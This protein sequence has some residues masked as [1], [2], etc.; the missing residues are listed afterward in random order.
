MKRLFKISLGVVVALFTIISFSKCKV[1][2]GG[3]YGS[4]PYL[5]VSLS[6]T[7][8]TKSSQ[9]FAVQV[10]SNR[11]VK[12]KV[13]EG[14]SW[15][16]AEL[17]GE[18]LKLSADQNELEEERV[19]TVTLSTPNET[20]TH[21]LTIHQDA[22]GELTYRGDLLLKSHAEVL[23]NTYTKAEGGL[24]LGNL[25]FTIAVAQNV[26]TPAA[27]SVTVRFGDSLVVAQPSDISQVSIEKLNEMIHKIGKGSLVAIN[28]KLNSLPLTLV[29]GNKVR[30]LYLDYNKISTLP[31]TEEM[32]TLGLTELS[33]SDNGI[34]DISSLNGLNSIKYLNLGGN[35]I[36][37]IS[38]LS[39]SESITH[40][41]LD[42]NANLYNIDPLLSFTNL[43]KVS[44]KG[45]PITKSQIDILMDR[46]EGERFEIDTTG[47]IP[48]NSP[49]PQLECMET[50]TISDNSFTI[51]AKV[52]SSGASPI[53]RYG[54]YVGDS[55]GI[56]AMK[57]IEASFNSGDNTISAT[58]ENTP[59]ENH[60]TFFR[61]CAHNS[62][63]EGFSELAYFGRKDSNGD[64]LITNE[65]DLAKFE[66]DHISN[67]KGSIFVG[68]GLTSPSSDYITL[69]IGDNSYY[70]NAWNLKTL[71]SL[72]TITTI[73]KGIYVANT[74][75]SDFS[76]IE[77]IESIEMVWLKKNKISR[78]PNLSNVA[79]LKYLNLSENVISDISPIL[80]L[81]NLEELYLGDKDRANLETNNIALLDGLERMTALKRLD[82]SGLPIHKYQVDSL[83][84]KLPSCNI[85]FEAGT[86]APLLPTVEGVKVVVEG[87]SVTFIGKVA[88]HGGSNVIECGFYYGIDKKNLTKVKSE[89]TL[90]EENEFS[91]TID[92]GHITDDRYYYYPY[93]INSIGEA[94][95]YEFNEFMLVKEN[96]SPVETSNCY[97]VNNGGSYYFNASIIGNGESGII[98][99]ASF[100]T[101]SAAITPASAE[102]VWMEKDGMISGVSYNSDTQ[103]IEFASNG[104]RGNAII[105]AKDGSGKIIWSW[106]IWVTD[107][108]KEHIY[109]TF[110]GEQIAVMDRNLG[111][112]RANRGSGDQWKESV[113]MAYQ[114][115]RKDPLSV[116]KTK[117]AGQSAFTIEESIE[118]PG[119]AV[120]S[121]HSSWVSPLNAKLWGGK[122]TIYDPCP[123]GYMVAPPT[124]WSGFS[125]TGGDVTI[126]QVKKDGGWDYGLNLKYNE[127]ETAWYPANFNVYAGPLANVEDHGTYLSH[128]LWGNAGVKSLYMSK[129]NNEFRPISPGNLSV[130]GAV[131]CVKDQEYIQKFA[132]KVT[133]LQVSNI[134][135]S[136]ANVYG[137][138]TSDI[139][140]E[141]IERGFVWSKT[142]NPSIN[143]ADQMAVGFGV[144]IYSATL[145][146]LS[147][148]TTYYLRAYAI[149]RFGVAYGDEIKFTTEYGGVV[150]NLSEMETSNCYIVSPQEG[151]FYSFD[152]SV[153]GNGAK[154]IIEG[155]S[156][157][158]SDVT[159]SPASVELLWEANRAKTRSE[160]DEELK[161]QSVFSFLDYNRDSKIVRF[162]T[163]GIPGNAVIAAKD[164]NG[165]I[166]WSWHIWITDAPQNH[167]YINF[168][169]KEY[170]MMDRNIGALSNKRGSDGKD[171][172]ESIGLL[173][174]WG[175]KDPLA[176]CVDQFQRVD[177][178]YTMAEAI[179]SPMVFSYAGSDSWLP[180]N[181]AWG[182]VKTIYDPC[183]VGYR[184]PPARFWTGFTATGGSVTNEEEL[185]VD[186]EYSYGY[187]FYF[188]PSNTAWYPTTSWPAYT[189]SDGSMWMSEYQN[190]ISFSQSRLVF[191]N[192]SYPSRLNAVRCV[193]DAEYVDPQLPQIS[194]VTVAGVTSSSVD[195][196]AEIAS[197]GNSPITDR[198]F[199]W[200]TQINPSIE[201]DNK[202]SCGSGVGEFSSQIT[203][204]EQFTRYYVRAYATNKYGTVYSPNKEITTEFS[205]EDIYLSDGGT[206]N[207]YVVSSFK[208]R[209][210]FNA[211][212]IGNGAI[213][214]IDGANFHTTDPSISPASA[215]I[216]WQQGI[217][218]ATWKYDNHALI[219][220]NLS[221]DKESK[222]V[223]FV[224]GGVEGNALIAVKDENG[225]ILWSWH[226]WVTDTPVNHF[227]ENFVKKEFEV[228]D[229]NLGAL[230]SERGSGTTTVESSG[231]LYQWGRK[232]PVAD[233]AYTTLSGEQ[234]TLPKSIQNPT[235]F[236]KS[237]INSW[238]R[239][240]NKSLWG[241]SKTIYDPCP[242]GYRVAQSDLWS[243]FSTTGKSV[244]S[245]SSIN[246]EGG[247]DKGFSF[248]VNDG[249]N[250]K[251]WYP[252][253]YNSSSGQYW[254]SD[255]VKNSDYYYSLNFNSGYLSPESESLNYDMKSV[256]CVVDR[257][258][259]DPT[260]PSVTNPVA[261][262]VET[263]S[264]VIVS[265]VT[266]EGTSPVTERGIVWS[267]RKIT[268]A[269]LNVV[270]QEGYHKVS[271]GSGVGEFSVPIDDLYAATTYWVYSYAKSRHGVTYSEIIS[272]NTNFKAG[273][274]DVKKG[275]E[276][277]W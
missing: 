212:I 207:C 18:L 77:K 138:V 247:F 230:S 51:R 153:I 21:T 205:G 128:S 204:L 94:H 124:T 182:D 45:L 142:K 84:V 91:S 190:S 240:T 72:E 119:S 35:D 164:E 256:R 186:G 165:K 40:L 161:S 43:Q 71:K 216:L 58:L 95:A 75:V 271:S 222:R 170:I 144:G 48:K 160:S 90:S 225:V 49:L 162:V 273:N 178:S 177:G 133:T 175:R 79:N 14:G 236:P 229:R 154:G 121:S 140:E 266:D 37:D 53:T 130:F 188:D 203:D 245:S 215:E 259:I 113:G 61:A 187:H 31:T 11:R 239:Y 88:N 235:T 181:K 50:I 242:W 272:F 248:I 150:N 210:S 258:Y 120:P 122:K 269:D 127:V 22:S 262:Q 34:T 1:D 219:I 166:L 147:S 123:A 9:Q 82:L 201:S 59:T 33:L 46:I 129:T 54:F 231:L 265:S 267:N 159:I 232:D 38:P 104:Q 251:A 65:A 39:G 250:N 179:E 277:N 16:K 6:D 69:T 151:V 27:S 194:D 103:S 180:D 105:A 155:A 233:G 107:T 10:E 146:G 25:E 139:G 152:A 56:S 270:E 149:N 214:I 254:S 191:Y 276:Y 67:V 74:A 220:G 213:G 246:A 198:G 42:N 114:W 117:M 228:M 29:S 110:D 63:G 196:S 108:P 7:T 24:F 249:D 135:T 157:H 136:S 5:K 85:T 99:E 241:R 145:T 80:P 44:L 168:D 28:T 101:N 47:I 73:E 253:V 192:N 68:S 20:A 275:D 98:P 30:R 64:V 141:V 274:E 223:S 243:G 185:R 70:F 26:A 209:Y 92:L 199:V 226:I 264:V 41:I 87:T 260:F 156:F 202:S 148:F 81:T 221:L 57:F 102:V 100:H 36:I 218:T 112:I 173:Y 52:L 86:R 109:T 261:T 208:Q 206:A 263:E 132:P 12:V 32:G 143:S 93:A 125:P 89:S 8:I 118:N 195:V 66:E 189:Y 257:E 255:P 78:V 137:E 158:T 131:R 167:T 268:N 252:V 55:K 244:Y 126:D 76:F 193:K 200:S 197:E 62:E 184:V 237:N 176:E 116:A 111:A 234:Y 19:T 106:H 163:S 17:N 3:I 227:Y 183:P 97:I 211:G 224:T 96:L 13:E 115:G 174:Q 169:K 217:N 172:N 134:T 2:E 238:T 23:N 15:L 60:L 83:S 4:F 171:A